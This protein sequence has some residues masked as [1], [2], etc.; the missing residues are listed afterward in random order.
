M[1][2]QKFKLNGFH[3]ESCVRLA[4]MKLKKI[5]GVQEVSFAD[6]EGNGALVADHVIDKAE[7][8]KALE[9][10]EYTVCHVE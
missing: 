7:I 2:E 10:T 9:G 6:T 5:A 1:N 3:C 4:T 8:E